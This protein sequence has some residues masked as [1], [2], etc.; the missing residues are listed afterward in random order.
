M[1]EFEK[2]PHRTRI[3]RLVT[4]MSIRTGPMEVPQFGTGAGLTSGHWAAMLSGFPGDGETALHYV[5]LLAGE[6]RHRK[7]LIAR[8]MYFLSPKI[9]MGMP[10][11]TLSGSDLRDVV[12]VTVD[13]ERHGGKVMP[14]DAARGGIKRKRWERLKPVHQMTVDALDDVADQVVRHLARACS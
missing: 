10:S 4:A 8:L 13:A 5:M 3:E 9:L 12:A 1:S 7:P 2:N 11:L 14:A 6:P